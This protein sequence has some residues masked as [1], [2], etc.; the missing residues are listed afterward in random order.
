MP[1]QITSSDYI[2]TVEAEI[3]GILYKVRKIGAG[4]SLDV[5]QVMDKMSKIRDESDKL[6]E[7]L[8]DAKD[9]KDEEALIE[10]S[11]ELVAKMA[12]YNQQ[13]I[14]VYA[15]L[16]NDGGDGSKS[17][18]LVKRVGVETVP[19]LLDVIFGANNNG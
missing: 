9:K 3:D 13:L 18:E 11:T 2:K 1:I 4:D 6:Q 12:G 5:S 10:K 15:R 14:A 8:K 16:F 7:A 19:K 17:I